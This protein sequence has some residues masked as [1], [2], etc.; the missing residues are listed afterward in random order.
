MMKGARN[1]VT[2][3]NVPCNGC[4]ACCRND[5]IVL[6]PEMG[7]DQ[8]AYRTFP[9]TNP[10][11]GRPCRMLAKKPDGACV[12]LGRA[13]CTIH[14]RAPA[15]CREFDC[16]SFYRAFSRPERRRLVKDGH[17]DAAVFAAGRARLASLQE[18]AE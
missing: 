12:Y 2:Q 15:I 7:D 9:A 16:R 6:L 3:A 1:S 4:T 10:I 8:A 5:A 18:A 17:C 14:G 11:T 13:G